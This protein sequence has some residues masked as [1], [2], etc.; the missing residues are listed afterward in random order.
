HWM[1]VA[2]QVADGEI[3][4]EWK[5]PDEDGEAAL[6]TARDAATDERCGVADA[7][8]NVFS[9]LWRRDPTWEPGYSPEPDIEPSWRAECRVQA[10]L[11]R[12]VF[13]NPFRLLPQ[14]EAGWLSWNDGTVLTLARTIY[15]Q[16]SFDLL[17]VLADAL[18]EAGCA[19]ADLLG[20]LR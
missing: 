9:C 17:P 2:R 7:A 15:Q 13:G 12:D 11:V 4:E 16:E 14:I 1:V 19:D 6:C 20:H 18:E 8:R 3:R 10:E 5:L